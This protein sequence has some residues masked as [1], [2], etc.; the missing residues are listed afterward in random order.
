MKKS[1]VDETEL[2]AIKAI[3]VASK[4]PFRTA[5]KATLGIAAAQLVITV[6][7]FGGLI[8]LGTTC[9]LLAR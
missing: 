7:F 2:M 4:T 1:E 8:V 6:V 3:A 5:F 9:Y